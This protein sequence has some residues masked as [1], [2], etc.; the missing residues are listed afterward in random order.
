M[1]AQKLCLSDFGAAYWSTN[2]FKYFTVSAI[3]NFQ[4]R[5]APPYIEDLIEVYKL[6]KTSHISPTASFDLPVAI[7]PIL[8]NVLANF[9]L[10]FLTFRT[11]STTSKTKNCDIVRCHS[12]TDLCRKYLFYKKSLHVY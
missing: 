9:S 5:F 7:R 6:S 2:L 11:L 10:M 12:K 3:L 4:N 8:K 1:E